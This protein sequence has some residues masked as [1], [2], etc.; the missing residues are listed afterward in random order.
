M[1]EYAPGLGEIA[2]KALADG[3]SKEATAGVLGISRAAFYQWLNKYPEFAAAVAEGEAAS[4]YWWEDK[5]REACSNGEF[6]AT[7]WS[8]NMRNR[9]GWS[10]KQ[11]HEHTG[12]D[13][14]A[15]E[16]KSKVLNVVG[17]DSDAT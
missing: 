9:F 7:V 6:N 14:G 2:R 16:T 13:G 17:V 15:I 12:K 11:S 3:Y 4:Q 8:L 5:G 1:A 10:D